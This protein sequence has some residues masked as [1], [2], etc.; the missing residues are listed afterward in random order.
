MR[1]CVLLVLLLLAIGHAAAECWTNQQLAIQALDIATSR[2]PLVASNPPTVLECSPD[3]FAAN[4]GGSYAASDH[5]ILIPAWMTQ[6]SSELSTVLAHELGHAQVRLSGGDGGPDGHSAAWVYAMRRAGY[7]TEVS[8]MVQFSPAVAQLVAREDEERTTRRPVASQ[9]LPPTVT[10][11][12]PQ[13]VRACR[14]TPAVSV[15]WFGRRHFSQ[16]IVWMQTCGWEPQ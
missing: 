9:Y 3:E 1:A 15:I 7:A 5:A 2:F 10:S 13:W 16:Q 14:M 11:V 12:Q 8:R 4:A 6:R